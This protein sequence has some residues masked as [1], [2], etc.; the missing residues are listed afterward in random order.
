MAKAV[1]RL[2]LVADEEQLLRSSSA[3]QVDQVRLKA[4]RV[5]ELVDHDRTES[6]LLHLSDLVVV[7]EQL[8]RAQLQVFE[9]ER[10]FTILGGR[11]GGRES[12][13][14]LLQQLSVA[15]GELL[16]RERAHLVPRVVERRRPC[17]ARARVR[18]FEQSLGQAGRLQQVD[19]VTSRCPLQI[20]GLPVGGE[21]LRFGEQV[22]DRVVE[23]LGHAGLELELASR[24]AQRVVDADQHLAEATGAVGREELPT[25]RLIGSAELLQGRI[26]RLALQNPSLGLVQHSEARVDPRRQ[27]IRRQQPTAEPMNRR[28]PGAVEVAREVRTV[29]L[30][31]A[32]SDPC[33]QLP[34]GTIRVGDDE[35]RIDVE[36][37]LRDRIC[38]PLHEHGRL[39]GPGAGRDEGRTA[40]I[41]RCTL[42]GVR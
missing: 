29:E 8:A 7:L 24:R 12:R 34:G 40:R 6:K 25:V 35:Q 38:K 30:E 14:Q 5:L 32:R 20:R 36:A 31:Q 18:Q 3:Q 23:A 42:L 28:D 27:R 1:D 11:V 21:R 33:A 17:S 4:V 39:S 16:Q 19:H 26:E 15:G 9:V 2:E 13:Q 22:D 41:D 10:R 37:L